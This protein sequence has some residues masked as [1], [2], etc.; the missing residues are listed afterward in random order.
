MGM[1]ALENLTLFFAGQPRPRPRRVTPGARCTRSPRPNLPASADPLAASAAAY[2]TEV[3]ELLFTPAAR[4]RARPRT[5]TSSRCCAASAPD[6]GLTDRSSSCARL[7]AQGIWFQLLSIAEQNAAMR[8]RRQ[9]ETER[10]LEQVRGTFAQ[11]FADAAPAGDAGRTRDRARCSSGSGSGRS[12]PPIPPRPSGSRCWRSTAGSTA[13]WW[14]S[15]RPAGRRASARALIDQLRN[16][17]ELLWMT[18]RTAAGE[19]DGAAGGVLGPALLQRDAVRGGA[20]DCW[21]SST[22]RWPQFYPG[23]RFDDAAVLPVRL[24]DRRRPRRQ[25]VRHQRG[26]P[27]HAGREPAAPACSAIGSG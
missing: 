8:R 15:S 12:S 3:A 10:G 25:S 16:E 17:I 18:G 7:R 2:A 24:L 11:V 21:R 22:A 19:A 26:H 6:L 23:E 5:P 9:T 13:G 4:R 1:R 14:T 20:R 27:Q